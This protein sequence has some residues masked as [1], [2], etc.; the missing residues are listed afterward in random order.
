MRSKGKGKVK[1]RRKAKAESNGKHEDDGKT[2]DNDLTLERI[3]VLS[4]TQSDKM[5]TYA[6]P[7]S[8]SI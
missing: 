6:F 3:H 8:R 5:D 1:V 2:K 4:H 7:K